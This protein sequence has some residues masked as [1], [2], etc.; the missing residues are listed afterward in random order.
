MSTC[1]WCRSVGCE[2]GAREC[3][4]VEFNA[5]LHDDGQ[6][7]AVLNS[8]LARTYLPTH[9]HDDGQGNAVLRVHVRGE[10]APVRAE[11]GRREVGLHRLPHIV[12]EGRGVCGCGCAGVCMCACKSVHEMVWHGMG[13]ASLNNSTHTHVCMHVY[14]HMYVPFF[15]FP[16][17]S[18]CCCP[19]FDCCCCCCCCCCFL[20]T[21]DCAAAAAGAGDAGG[22]V[23]GDDDDGDEEEEEEEEPSPLPCGCSG[24]F[25][26]GIS[27]VL[28]C[29]GGDESGRS[30]HNKASTRHRRQQHHPASKPIP[31]P[32]RPTHRLHTHDGLS[33]ARAPQPPRCLES[34]ADLL[35]LLAC[36][37]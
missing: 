32:T 17:A 20:G 3:E 16:P 24:P 21:A 35:D 5:H 25:L 28:S 37:A 12:L 14:I 36:P 31:V 30:A 6:G 9:L 10:E 18:P 26:L 19:C 23:G 22:A 4:W 2:A 13:G 7:D 8:T 1:V 33:R 27:V 15:P 34:A 29:W 11:V